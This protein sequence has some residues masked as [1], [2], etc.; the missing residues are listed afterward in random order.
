M[1]VLFKA[2]GKKTKDENFKSTKQHVGREKGKTR[3][4][5]KIQ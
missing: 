3:E 4:N 1:G 5:L 2:G